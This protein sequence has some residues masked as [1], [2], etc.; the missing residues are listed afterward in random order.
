MAGN[1]VYLVMVVVHMLRL[2]VKTV[3]IPDLGWFG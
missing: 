1:Q 3:E 2:F